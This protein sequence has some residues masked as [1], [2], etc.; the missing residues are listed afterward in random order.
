M[1]QWLCNNGIALAS[2][3]QH[4]IVQRDMYAIFDIDKCT[5]LIDQDA[6][7]ARVVIGVGFFERLVIG[8]T[9]GVP[10]RLPTPK[11]LHHKA[12]LILDHDTDSRV[13]HTRFG[14]LQ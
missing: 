14:S 11:P 7:L 5:T 3:Y 4:T 13:G 6:L 10:R 8:S 9:V 2:T 12:R 1:A